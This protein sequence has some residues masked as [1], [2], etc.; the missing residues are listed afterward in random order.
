MRD[1]EQRRHT[2]D[3]CQVRTN[4]SKHEIVE[5]DIACDLFGYGLRGAWVRE[6]ELCSPFR[7]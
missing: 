2:K 3:L 5:E 4:A 7:E 1:L 6:A